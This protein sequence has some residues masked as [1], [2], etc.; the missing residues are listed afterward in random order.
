MY[1][2]YSANGTVYGTKLWEFE[3]VGSV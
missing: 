1:L 2:I 3:E